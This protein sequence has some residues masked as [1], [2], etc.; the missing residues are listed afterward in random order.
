MLDRRVSLRM[1]E[2]YQEDAVPGCS[3]VSIVRDNAIAYSRFR[4]P[5]S[6]WMSKST[7]PAMLQTSTTRLITRALHLPPTTCL[8][9]GPNLAPVFTKEF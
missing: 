7:A 3:M 2:F 9:S 1:S 6:T 4:E 8:T 5:P